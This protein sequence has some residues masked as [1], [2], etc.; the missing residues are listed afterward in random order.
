MKRNRQEYDSNNRKFHD[1]WYL[2]LLI[3]SK[4]EEE[5]KGEKEKK[6]ERKKKIKYWCNSW[7]ITIIFGARKN[8]HDN[9]KNDKSF[10][11]E[12]SKKAIT[13]KYYAFE[14]ND[15]VKSHVFSQGK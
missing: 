11:L 10:R 6:E 13:I 9:I 15:L 12:H 7:I 14:K 1:S 8:N 5:G 4:K 2:N 3:A